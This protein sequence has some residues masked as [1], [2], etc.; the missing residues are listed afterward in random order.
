MGKT[1]FVVVDM[2][3]GL[4]ARDVYQKE[5]LLQNIN[6]LIDA[7]HACDVPVVFFRHTNSSF[8]QKDTDEW[9]LCAELH[10]QPQD[11]VFD[12]SHSSVFKEKAFISWLEKMGIS[13][14][15]FAGLVSNGCVQNSCREA[16]EHRYKVVLPLDAHSTWHKNAAA[17]IED[18]NKRLSDEGVTVIKSQEIILYI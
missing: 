13:E 1:V 7:F 6:L 10:K 18:W 5:T 11:I 2:Q 3:T 17:V 9:Q 12:K 16:L 8:S 4:F 14:I 15:Y